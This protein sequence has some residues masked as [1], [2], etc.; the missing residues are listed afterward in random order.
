MTKIPAIDSAVQALR[1]VT[2]WLRLHPSRHVRRSLR[3]TTDKRLG[4]VE[5]IADVLDRL[6]HRYPAEMILCP[7]HHE[8]FRMIADLFR[9]CSSRLKHQ[10][11]SVNGLPKSEHAKEF[12]NF[13]RNVDL[14]LAMRVHAMSPSIGLGT[15]TVAL[16]SQHRMTEFMADAGLCS[17]SLD[18]FSADFEEELWRRCEWIL[19]N[20]AKAREEM[21]SAAEEMRQRT[22]IFNQRI[23]QLVARKVRHAA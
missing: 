1:S 6:A 18:V 21:R 17:Y 7:H 11:V 19:A 3:R 2:V 14:T 10:I 8:D 4:F 9:C 5:R 16:C 23:E 22:R 13:Y 12:Y 15:P 20:S